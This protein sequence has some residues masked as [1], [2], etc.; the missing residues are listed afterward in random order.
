MEEPT[1]LVIFGTG[2][3]AE[4]C[5]YYFLH[6]SSYS[7]L[8]HTVDRAYLGTGSIVGVPIVA[9]EDCAAQF[10]PKE[11]SLFVALGYNDGNQGRQKKCAQARQSG[12]ELAS[13]LDPSVVN[14]AAKIGQNC[15]FGEGV[16]LQPFSTIGDGCLIRAGAIVGHHCTIGSYAYISPGVVLCGESA[17]GDRS[18]IGAGSILQSGVTLCADVIVG[19]GSTVNRDI[20]EPGTY[21]GYPARRVTARQ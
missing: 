10:A 4:V 8:A 12:Y 9:F 16:I 18:F 21:L 15:M 7:V 11:H 5:A 14:H 17:V 2:R 13:Y 6:N 19:S 3:L 20:T 1:N